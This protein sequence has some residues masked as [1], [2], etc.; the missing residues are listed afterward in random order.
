MF[1]KV[2]NKKELKTFFID[3]I[4]ILISCLFGAF[5]T[6]GVLIPHGLTTGG[7]TGVARIIQQFID[8]DFSILFYTESFIVLLLVAIFLGIKDAKK[9]L[10]L[11]VLYPSVTFIV[12]RMNVQLLDENDVL[13]A[14]VFCGVFTGIHVGLL[15]WRGYATADT[16]AIAKILNRRCFPGVNPSRL[17]LF[18][19][20]VIIICS[21]FFYGVNI[22]LYALITQVILSKTAE[23]V[24]YGFDGSIVSV[25]II[26]EKLDEIKEF[27]IE[28]LD[29]GISSMK[30]TG[31]YTD[32]ERIQLIV[33]CS[34]GESVLIKRKL[35][36]IDRNAFV[37]VLKVEDVWGSGRGFGEIHKNH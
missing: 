6:I 34:P 23:I 10:M 9:I 22:A 16:D 36:Q 30:I 29:R 26:T 31:E 24:M 21:I 14:V 4:V 35:A 27:V 13:L 33:T 20:A 8:V 1:V 15:F 25:L 28:E 32:T 37:T 5:S 3:F 19:D 17:L 12:E 7:I 2:M 11:T 18:V